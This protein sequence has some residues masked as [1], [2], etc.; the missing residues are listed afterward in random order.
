MLEIILTEGEARVYREK[1][2]FKKVVEKLHAQI[3]AHTDPDGYI[4]L[5]KFEAI[6]DQAAIE[7][8]EL[9]EVEQSV[10]FRTDW[11]I[12]EWWTSVIES[13]SYVCGAVS[14]YKSFK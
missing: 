3:E 12:T 13:Y 1:S 5:D 6:T 9:F 7:L 14:L 10:F 2:E 4:E 8:G 11:S